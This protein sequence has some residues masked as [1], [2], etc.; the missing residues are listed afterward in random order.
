MFLSV[1]RPPPAAL[2]AA[3]L[4][5]TA[6]PLALNCGRQGAPLPS[7]QPSSADETI[8]YFLPCVLSRTPFLFTTH[9]GGHRAASM[10]PS[11]SIPP[12][13]SPDTIYL[14]SA[15]LFLLVARLVALL[16]CPSPLVLSTDTH[17]FPAHVLFLSH[18]FILH[19]ASTTARQSLSSSNI[20]T[21]YA[22]S[23]NLSCLCKNIWV[24][25]PFMS[26]SY[27]CFCWHSRIKN[28]YIT[29]RFLTFVKPS[30]LHWDWSLVPLTIKAFVKGVGVPRTYR[31]TDRQTLSSSSHLF[32]CSA[33]TRPLPRV[34]TAGN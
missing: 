3:T 14:M 28:R 31:H 7:L 27:K 33:D 20:I 17:V 11:S 13:S 8:Q 9:Y 34:P 32:E 4:R 23:R 30:S 24:F 26:P 2:H 22:N 19:S 15:S 29:S 12:S 16:L 10:H 5:P 6:T 21:E 1:A 25:T 18:K